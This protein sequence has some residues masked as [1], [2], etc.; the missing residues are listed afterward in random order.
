[1]KL[2][3]FYGS[4]LVRKGYAAW[5]L[6]PFMFFRDAKEDVNDRLFRH[7]MEHVYQVMRDGWWTFYIKYLWWLYRYGYEQHPYEQEARG[8]EHSPL[9]YIE[10]R[11]KDD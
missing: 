8:M 10:R 7:E 6:Y 1:M 4:I 9:S 2:R 11:F 3:I 5:V